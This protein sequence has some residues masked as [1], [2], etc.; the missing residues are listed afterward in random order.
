MV[1]IMSAASVN[2]QNGKIPPALPAHMENKN[3]GTARQSTPDSDAL[4]SS[5]DDHDHNTSMSMS[6][7]SAKSLPVHRPGRRSSWLNEVQPSQRKFS[8]GGVPFTSGGSQPPTPAGDSGTWDNS[9]NASR[10]FPWNSQVWQKDHRPTRIGEVIPSPTATFH[11]DPR[12]PGSSRDQAAISGTLPFDIP[13]EPNRKIVRSQS[14]SAGQMEKSPGLESPSAVPGGHRMSKR[15]PLLRRTSRP[16]VLGMDGSGEY[17]LDSLREDEVDEDE[18]DNGSGVQGQDYNSPTSLKDSEPLTPSA[19]A[20]PAHSPS[21]TSRTQPSNV[22]PS[23]QSSVYSLSH[24]SPNMPLNPLD[25]DYA[26]EDE[27]VV[28]SMFGSNRYGGLSA[29]QINAPTTSAT[30]DSDLS[31]SSRIEGARRAQ[32][33]SSLG[34]GIPEEGSQSRRHSFATEFV[35]RPRNPSLTQGFAAQASA[36]GAQFGDES[37]QRGQSTDERKFQST[38][39]VQL[40]H[41]QKD[42][43]LVDLFRRRQHQEQM[44]K[45][46]QSHE[47]HEH[48]NDHNSE[49]AYYPGPESK[50]RHNVETDEYNPFAVPNVFTRPVRILYIV[51]FKCNRS[52]IYYIPDNTGLQVQPGDMVVVEGDRGQ[53]L[54]TVQRA[55]VTLEE[56]KQLKIDF[57]KKHFQ[58]LMMFSRLFPHVANAAANGEIPFPTTAVSPTATQSGGG[59][60]KQQQQQQQQGGASEAEPRPKM[61]KRV[62]KP[63][64]IHLLREKEGNEAK[65]KR[66]CQSKVNEHGLRMEILDAEFQQ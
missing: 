41:K 22:A 8:L 13:L 30:A 65:A 39:Q 23:N 36:Y 64:E 16:S 6:M 47:K 43:S 4:L 49:A 59:Q 56:A 7:H 11:E 51:S 20:K 24:T 37:F 45:Q 33:Q 35:S 9:G 63:D 57:T 31:R 3:L 48:I 2:V 27:D 17:N 54:G 5:D 53:D 55:N 42:S 38:F 21:Q 15:G 26:V 29:S 61:I 14:Y 18:D 28:D 52:D 62:A 44:Q 34:F 32:W 12:S 40:Q 46:K 66:V 50:S 60:G 58:C 19:I 1:G 10:N 25:S